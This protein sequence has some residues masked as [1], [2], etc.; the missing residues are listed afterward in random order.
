[1]PSMIATATTP[2]LDGITRERFLQQLGL[3]TGLLDYGTAT[4]GTAEY[5]EDTVRLK[6]YN[7]S[8]TDY[9]GWVRISSTTDGAAPVGQIRAIVEPKPEMA[10]IGVD[11]PFSAAVG[12]GDKYELWKVNPSYVLDMID[13]VLVEDLYF[14]VWSVLSEVPDF[15]MEQSHTTDWTASSATVTKQTAEPKLTSSGRRYLRVVSTAANGYAASNTL[16]LIPG[17]SYHMSALAR[18]GSGATAKL[19]AYDETNGA[20]IASVT[21]DNRM[22]VR[23]NKNFTAP[24]T[25]HQISIRLVSVESGVTTEW[26]EVIAFGQQSSDIACPWWMKK[27]DQ[28]KAVFVLEPILADTDAWEPALIGY[29]DQ[30]W[31]IIESRIGGS[32]FRAQNRYGSMVPFPLY[33]YGVRNEVAYSDDTTDLKY[34]NL[35]LF[36]ECVKWRIYSNLTEPLISGVLD[37]KSFK[38]KAAWAL[39]EYRRLQNE[40]DLELNQVFKSPT[41]IARFR[42]SRFDYGE[43]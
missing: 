39:K 17:Q 41:P 30:A 2:T 21:S 26:D 10:R 6:S 25:C 14:P 32:K 22:A 36:L 33:V 19:Q 35:D 20:E 1:M 4:D 3:I 16:T 15:D 34:L 28:I 11:A 38:D 8:P 7:A 9:T 31:D 12:A 27:K 24:S 40:Q 23:L 29:H 43:Y 5:I 37:A 18:C 13:R 42:D